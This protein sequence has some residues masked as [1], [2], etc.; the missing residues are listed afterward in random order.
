MR[1]E[2]FQK[3]V[4]GHEKVMRFTWFFFSACIGIYPVLL[5]FIPPQVTTNEMVLRV[6]PIA[7][8]IVA[9]A[10]LLLHK[11]MFSDSR[12]SAAASKTFDARNLA[13]RPKTQQ[14][15]Q[16]LFATLSSLTPLE[17]KLYQVVR[18]VQAANV[19]TLMLNE[20]VAICGLVL[21]PFESGIHSYLPYGVAA[22]ALNIIFFPKVGSIVERAEALPAFRSA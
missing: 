12:L 17:A 8:A 16:Q 18:H 20:V 6:L 19:L 15:N 13:T 5:L 2:A 11:T 9:G 14:L 7:A 4:S 22:L 10:S 3:A 1:S 21:A